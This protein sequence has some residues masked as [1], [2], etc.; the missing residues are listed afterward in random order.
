MTNS[1][2]LDQTAP[3]LGLHCLLKHVYPKKEYSIA[4]NKLS[5]CLFTQ[6]IKMIK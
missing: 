5:I 1:V 6:L 3:L 4:P 2:D